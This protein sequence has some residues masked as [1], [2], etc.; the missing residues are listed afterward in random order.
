[1]EK[2]NNDQTVIHW[3][4]LFN[5]IL[6]ITFV[7]FHGVVARNH[8]KIMHVPRLDILLSEFD[9]IREATTRSRQ[10]CIYNCVVLPAVHN[11]GQG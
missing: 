8:F 2:R 4:Y 1:M 3:F 6:I 11:R 10:D 7:S 9:N 5:C